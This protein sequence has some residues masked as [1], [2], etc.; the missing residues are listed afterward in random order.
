MRERVK[1]PQEISNVM[2]IWRMGFGILPEKYIKF[3]KELAEKELEQL[4]AEGVIVYHT[5]MKSDGWG[6]G[7]RV[8]WVVGEYCNRLFK[9]KW[10]DG[11]QEFFI[12]S[13]NG[14]A[15]PLN[16]KDVAKW[17]TK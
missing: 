6:D 2:E 5:E 4:K 15:F 7:M 3:H 12:C 10:N 1:L 11:N 17:G 8:L 14:G 9:L 13:E 16:L